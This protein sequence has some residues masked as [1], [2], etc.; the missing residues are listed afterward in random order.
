MK[1]TKIL[2]LLLFLAMLCIPFLAI[3]TKMPEALPD[4]P[5]VIDSGP[6]AQVMTLPS[7]SGINPPIRF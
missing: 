5:K 7:E 4:A 6:A 2:C 1:G 3:G